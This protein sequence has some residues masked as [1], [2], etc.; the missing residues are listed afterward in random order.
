MDALD[1]F[2]IG[3]RAHVLHKLP[4]APYGYRL[5]KSTLENIAADPLRTAFQR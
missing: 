5:R 2:P 3:L 1:V 4:L